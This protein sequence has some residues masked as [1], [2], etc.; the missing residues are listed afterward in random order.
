MEAE[1][2]TQAPVALIRAILLDG[3]TLKCGLRDVAP[4]MAFGGHRAQ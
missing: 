3:S 1:G 2:G 4:E